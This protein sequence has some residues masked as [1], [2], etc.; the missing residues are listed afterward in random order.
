MVCQD[1]EAPLFMVG[2]SLPDV[3]PGPV[4]RVE[5][6]TFSKWKRTAIT[7]S[8]LGSGLDTGSIISLLDD[9]PLI[10]EPDTPRDRLLVHWP[11]S[12][13]AGAHVLHL[14]A[15]DRAGNKNTATYHLLAKEGSP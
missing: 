11:D 8:D 14:E 5:D 2:D 7:L 10:V 15:T 3:L 6:V 4:S 12:M 9:L 1:L 13:T